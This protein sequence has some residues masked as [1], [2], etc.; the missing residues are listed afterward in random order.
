MWRLGILHIECKDKGTHNNP[1]P[2]VENKII[3]CQKTAIVLK[4][5][6]KNSL[7][8]PLNYTKEKVLLSYLGMR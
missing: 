4:R 3:F 8:F 7:V 6:C 1:T 5:D 2:Y